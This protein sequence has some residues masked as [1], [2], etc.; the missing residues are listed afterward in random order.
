MAK[1]THINFRTSN[2]IKS[3]FD[4]VAEKSGLSQSDLFEKMLELYK[5]EQNW[6]NPFFRCNELYQ[7][8]TEQIEQLQ[9]LQ[10]EPDVTPE[11]Q[12]YINFLGELYDQIR[13][14]PTFWEPKFKVDGEGDL[15]L[16]EHHQPI[17]DE[18]WQKT[19]PY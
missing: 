18:E 3:S 12:G 7:F 2:E 10:Y 4:E 6:R 1:T 19:K 16:D 11:M 8:V 14:Q 13:Q 9:F 17:L 5:Q 15:L